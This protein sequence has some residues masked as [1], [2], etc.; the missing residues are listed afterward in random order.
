M[1]S[2]IAFPNGRLAPAPGRATRAQHGRRP[3]L[4]RTATIV[5]TAVLGA[6]VA[7]NLHEL[8]HTAF[9]LLAGDHNASYELRCE[10]AG[11]GCNH[12]DPIGMTLAA[13]AAV[14][15]GGVLVTQIIA[16][17]LVLVRR[18]AGRRWRPVLTPL[19]VVFAADLLAQF[20]QAIFTPLPEYDLTKVDFTALA[21]LLGWSQAA[22]LAVLIGCSVGYVALWAT[23]AYRSRS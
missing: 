1:T 20:G 8:G 15:L 6:F 23:L 16:W 21:T 3:S 7:L 22:Y 5:F 19:I 17:S 13:K 11:F 18:R 14:T 4:R 9:A 2:S 12:F 10:P